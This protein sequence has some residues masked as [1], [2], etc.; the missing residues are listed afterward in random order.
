MGTLLLPITFA[1]PSTETVVTSPSAPSTPNPTVSTVLEGDTVIANQFIEGLNLTDFTIPQRR[2]VT[3]IKTTSNQTHPSWRVGRLL[4]DYEYSNNVIV[5]GFLKTSITDLQRNH[6]T[7]M[8]NDSLHTTSSNASKQSKTLDDNEESAELKRIGLKTHKFSSSQDHFFGKRPNRYYEYNIDSNPSHDKIYFNTHGNVV[9]ERPPSSSFVVHSKPL[10]ALDFVDVHSSQ[11]LRPSFSSS[12]HVLH[13]HDN[14][15]TDNDDSIHISEANPISQDDNSFEEESTTDRIYFLNNQA[16]QTNTK[17]KKK[18]IKRK[19]STTTTEESLFY[20]EVEDNGI[21]VNANL[22]NFD[23]SEGSVGG[24]FGHGIGVS[25]STSGGV[26]NNGG[27]GGGAGGVYG[28]IP[29]SVSNSG[30]VYGLIPGSVSTSVGVGSNGGGGDGGYG[31]IPGNSPAN[32]P[33]PQN[34]GPQ[35]ATP[36]FVPFP[37]LPPNQ[38]PCGPGYI[39]NVQTHQCELIHL[40]QPPVNTGSVSGITI[41]VKHQNQ[42]GGGNHNSGG[43]NHGNHGIPNGTPLVPTFV[44]QAAPATQSNQPTLDSSHFSGHN[45]KKKKRKRKKRKKRRRHPN[46]PNTIEK[47]KPSESSALTAMFDGDMKTVFKKLLKFFPLVALLSP[48]TFGFWSF[49]LSPL[50]VAMAIGSVLAIMMY[51]WHKNHSSHTRKLQPSVVIHRHQR[52]KPQWAP[53]VRPHRPP[54]MQSKPRAPVVHFPKI[55]PIQHI[56]HIQH[57][58]PQKAHPKMEGVR[59]SRPKFPLQNQHTGIRNRQD[60]DFSESD[61]RYIENRQLPIGIRWEDESA[62]SMENFTNYINSYQTKFK[63]RLD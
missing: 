7:S 20:D 13:I 40:G 55:G 1:R 32:I 33:F 37:V 41:D 29:G 8:V 14:E 15:P 16:I 2:Y 3:D 24:G 38:R 22:M 30:G 5:N 46:R 21:N 26:G 27:D 54:W 11:S 34:G 53:P 44:Y 42:N 6:F 59:W 18:K 58:S 51:P 60:D 23:D 19:P 52:T 62:V 31:L 50:L 36:H 43:H 35:F 4:S 48:L 56:H 9:L 39:L 61:T 49:L 12:H 17:K 63:K 28:L 45:D 10:S 47:P 25:V 57:T